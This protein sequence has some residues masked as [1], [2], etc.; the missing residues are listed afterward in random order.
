[1]S[2]K[3]LLER[4]EAASGPDTEIEMMMHVF[5]GRDAGEQKAGTLQH[6]YKY[7]LFT[8]EKGEKDDPFHFCRGFCGHPAIPPYTSSLDAA[9]KLVE[10]K[11]PDRC[12]EIAQGGNAV[13]HYHDHTRYHDAIKA[14]A[15][16]PALAL[17]AALLRAM[18]AEG[19]S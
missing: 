6:W 19:Q 15:E 17:V 7:G 1:M 8:V 18:I 16:T 12:W 2:L 11:F 4:V 5:L 14:E 9:V 10:E 3:Q 13:I